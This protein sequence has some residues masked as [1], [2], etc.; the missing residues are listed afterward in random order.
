ML[1]QSDS[2][3]QIERLKSALDSGNGEMHQLEERN[4]NLESQINAMDSDMKKLQTLKGEL[5]KERDQQEVDKDD[6]LQDLNRQSK[7]IDRWYVSCARF[8]FIRSFIFLTN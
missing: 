8:L 1:A 6:L 2:K 3:H 7:D 5:E 4:K